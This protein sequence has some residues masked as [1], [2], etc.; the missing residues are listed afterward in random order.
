MVAKSRDAA[1]ITGVS[2]LITSYNYGRYLSHAIDSARAQDVPG[3]E[4][5]IVDNASTDDSWDIIAAAAKADDRVRGYRNDSNIGMFANAQRTLELATNE[6]VLFL[7]ADDYLLPGHV[8]RLIGA[9][10]AH[11]D[12]D[13]FYTSYAK[14]RERGEYLAFFGHP[15]HLRGAY[16][17]GRNEFADLLTH[18]CYICM[19]TTLCLRSDLLANPAR[20]DIV[21]ADLNYYLRLASEGA[22]FG[23]IDVAGA[24][25]RLHDKEVTGEERYVATGTQLLDHLALL[26]QHLVARNDHLIEGREDG[27][28]R[29][30]NAKLANLRGYP[31]RFNAL[32][33]EIKPRV[34][35]LTAY[36]QASR[37]RSHTGVIVSP[38]VSVVFLSDA[39]V[40]ASITAVQAI[41][42]QEYDAKE[43]VVVHRARVNTSE[44]LTDAAHGTPVNVIVEDQSYPAAVAINDALRLCRG[45]IVVY[46]DAATS[47]QPG[48]LRRLTGHF[49]KNAIDAVVVGGDL[50]FS[51]GGVD[52]ARFEGF[53]GGARAGDAAFGEAVPLTTVAHR[54]SLIDE[55]GG[56]EEQLPYLSEFDYVSRLITGRTVGVDTELAVTIRKPVE[57]PHP[58]LANPNAYLAAMQQLFAARAVPAPIAEQRARHLQTV[59]AALQAFVA[60]KTSD[61][62]TAF[63]RVVRGSTESFNER[64]RTRPRILV[65]DDLVPYDELGRGYPRARKLL[66]SL[67]DGGYEVLFYPLVAPADTAPLDYGVPG[68]Q[69]LYGR[70]QELLALTLAELSPAIDAL[71]VSRPHNM[72][73]VRNALAVANIEKHWALIYDAEAIYV[74]RNAALA[75]LKGI[76][77]SQA[78]YTRELAAELRLAEH[79]DAISVVSDADRATFAQHFSAPIQTISFAIA[80]DPTPESFAQRRST[81]FIGAV[82]AG[83]PNEDALAWYCEF[84]EPRV[85]ATV[86]AP[87]QHAGVMQSA[88]VSRYAPERAVFLG[89]V[90]DLRPVYAQAR[91]FVAPTRY[92]AGLPQKVYEAAAHGVPVIATPL[93]ARQLGWTDG[94]ELLIAETPDQWVAAI[95]QLYN[96]ATLWQRLRDAALEAVRRTVA[97]DAFA[98]RVREVV[99]AAISQRKALV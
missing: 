90:P 4:V 51:R 95:M 34:E 22:R 3:L 68:V 58:A 45:E 44:L 9:H 93:L 72:A 32:F 24:V 48:H 14:V 79:C 96:D 87:V 62:A 55:I 10:A 20:T 30:L 84:V 42:A 69:V 37:A 43:L 33:P 88:V 8:A 16:Y 80:A 99:S 18:D 15:G 67:R 25:I 31:E 61:G 12:I 28:L 40:S 17:G 2:I 92:A 89:L 83:G 82:E 21:A 38:T 50:L 70:G 47:W 46:A 64:S 77:V 23:F 75:R 65:I 56:M 97:P 63:L 6:R 11:P 54:R 78:D 27:I 52:A 57:S 74:E 86:G 66:E 41:A 35:A 94:V 1:R 81:L 29:L 91:I 36:L 85:R 76:D 71:W 53:F 5:V 26:E 60:N 7:S 19:P 98:R 49:Q 39:D 73:S 13:Y 59:A